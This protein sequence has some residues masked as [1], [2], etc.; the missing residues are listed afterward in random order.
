MPITIAQGSPQSIWVP[1]K[2]GATIYVGGIAS[3][4]K[5]GP[6]EGIEMLPT[7]SGVVNVGN[8]DV[9]YGVV[10]GTNL[11][12]SLSNS[13]YNCEYIVGQTTTDPHDGS[14]TEYVGK[15]GPYSRGDQIAMAKIALITPDTILRASLCYKAVNAPPT[16]RT[17]TAG[18]GDGLS[19]TVAA[20]DFLP[21]AQPLQTIY[22]RKGANAGAYRLEDANNATGL[23]WDTATVSD[24]VARDVL[25]MVPMR[26]HGFSTVLFDATSKT[27]ID[28]Q[29][30]PL[31]N[32]TDRWVINV[33]RLDL[34]EAG[35]EFVEFMFDITHFGHF[36][37]SD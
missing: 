10:I 21:I 5:S 9:P 2:D 1:I 27:F 4:D 22:F 16:E 23:T 36:I 31:L 30:P 19:C 6:G 28:T 18:S 26:T 3:I 37:V 35:K 11:K 14:T 13:T 25:V 20:S 32:S 15:E 29:Y 7:A 17:L 33:V 24:P 34:H 8:N 12:N